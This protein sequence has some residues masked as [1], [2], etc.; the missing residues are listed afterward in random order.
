M[1]ISPIWG[2]QLV[3]AI[4]LSIIF[5]L[6]KALVVIASHIS[7]PPMW[8]VIIYASYWT[9]GLL[10]GTGSQSMSFSSNI[11]LESIWDNIFQYAIGAIVLAM[12]SGVIFGVMTYGML[13]IFKRPVSSTRS[14]RQ[15]KNN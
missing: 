11:T 5:R 1:G 8:P 12:V 15:N 9:G 6:N 13:R 7:I 4:A 2:F 14:S 10:L 3:T